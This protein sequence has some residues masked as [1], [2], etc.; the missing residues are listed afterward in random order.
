M[1]LFNTSQ[2]VSRH[3]VVY[4]S[5]DHSP[6]QGFPVG[7]GDFGA[8]IWTED[9]R[10]CGQFGKCDV[11]GGDDGES[12][13]M[14]RACGRFEIDFGF[15]LFDWLYLSDFEG[16]LSLSDG[17]L[18]IRADTP[19][20]QVLIRIRALSGLNVIAAD[21]SISKKNYLKDIDYITASID[22]FGSRGFRGWLN[23]INTD[24]RKGLSMPDS[25]ADEN[26]IYINESPGYTDF[27]LYCTAFAKESGCAKD[28]MHCEKQNSNRC[29]MTISGS[30]DFTLLFSCAT[31]Y[32]A[33]S[34]SEIHATAKALCCKAREKY[35]A[36]NHEHEQWWASFWNACFI[37]IPDD[38]V[39]NNYYLH[40]YQMASSS[41]GRFP[42]AFNGG[43]AVWNHDVRNWA[44]PHHWNNQQPYWG[45]LAAGHPEL[46]RVYIDTY[47]RIMPELEAYAKKQWG[48]DGCLL[49]QETHTFTGEI[50]EFP[51]YPQNVTPAMQ[52]AGFF[53]EYCLYTG[54]SDYLR[55]TAYPFM[56]KAAEFYVRQV[57]LEPDGR[58]C[59]KGT[60]VYE[61]TNSWSCKNSVTDNAH[62]RMLFAAC[63]RASEMLSCDQDKRRQWQNILDH[64]AD[65]PCR[66]SSDG[67][68]VFA[69]GYDDNGNII[70]NP[71]VPDAPDT[72]CGMCRT[73]AMV[74]P[75]GVLG[76]K[77]RKSDAYQIA[78]NTEALLEPCGLLAI[79]PAASVSARLGFAD[80]SFL[81]IQETIR[82]LQHF[83]QGLFCNIGGRESL[84]PRNS[85]MPDG[86]HAAVRDYLADTGLNYKNMRRREDNSRTDAPYRPFIQHGYEA[87]G[88]IVSGLNEMLL[89]SHEDVIR[90]FPA[91]P[92]DWETSFTLSARGGFLIT[93]V[94]K[95]GLPAGL[96][97]IES[98]LGQVLRLQNPFG[99]PFYATESGMPVAF[100]E[101][102]NIITL[103]TEPGKVYTFT[104]ISNACNL[105]AFDT[106]SNAGPKYYYEA[107]L[108]RPR[109]F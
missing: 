34:R 4:L 96:V 100:Q 85:V 87:S 61:I 79:S 58:Y 30:S 75:A 101:Q 105:P 72:G 70:K 95:A 97:I 69:I 10:L 6:Y 74:F 62:L 42:Q 108:G 48:Y 55:D 106:I 54:D 66:I 16:R 53:W 109:T 45:L 86:M 13:I 15:P 88:L 73:T 2:Y 12:P 71:W 46:V 98:R 94:K 82:L 17:T 36:L 37:H 59:I 8:M 67:K 3:D 28:I 89:Q 57:C 44:H 50:V 14:Q 32:E 19:F 78:C 5:P 60:S 99:G 76:I 26:G 90:V 64:Y 1:A 83:S 92:M 51:V 22:R 63:I 29:A 80:R 91:A 33:G 25:G 52:V 104:P 35:A 68:K 103:S 39:E 93:A 11:F 23:G 49:L 21:V 81:L 27:T 41:R 7:N 38:Y 18:T 65:Y 20:A 107:Q 102:E 9:S 40:L 56:K 84:S 47:A 24:P 31:A 43:I 77:D